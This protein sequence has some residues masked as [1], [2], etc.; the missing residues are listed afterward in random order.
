MALFSKVGLDENNTQTTQLFR[1]ISQ[2]GIV[3]LNY[4]S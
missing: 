1:S 3:N 4:S 2:G